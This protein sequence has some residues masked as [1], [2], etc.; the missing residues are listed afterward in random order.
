M[1]RYRRVHQGPRYARVLVGV[2]TYNGA[3]RTENLLRS[4][5]RAEDKTTYTLVL[6]DDGS[7][8]PGEVEKLEGLART[9]DATLLV[10][11]KNYG[12]TASWND[13][14]R[15]QE[16]TEFAVLLND[17]VLVQHG[18]LD[19]LIYFLEN[20]DC[21]AASPNLLFCDPG[22]VAAILEGQNVIP[23]HPVTRVP[24][25][26]RLVQSPEEP[27]GVVMCAL[28]SGFG[29]KRSVYNAVGGFDETMVQIYNE[30]ML[31]TEA[32]RALKLPSYCIPSPRIWHLWSVSFK[33]NPELGRKAKGDQAAYIRRFGGDFNGPN[34]THPRF[35][36]GTMPPRLVKW[37]GPDGQPHEKELTIQ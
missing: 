16:D 11:D 23:R 21:G 13:L 20:N 10:H 27:P 24:E 29:F 37:I 17:D 6:L 2:P 7:P 4:I 9:Y 14:V 25:P 22:E 3:A 33:E 5:H 26:D 36:V 15:Y 18:W 28:G 32:A 30:S 12:I 31:G 34:G 1:T 19:N 35:M 8:R